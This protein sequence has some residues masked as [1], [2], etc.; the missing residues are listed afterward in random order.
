MVMERGEWKVDE[1]SWSNEAPP[2]ATPAAA[3]AG[4]R[5]GASKPAAKAQS[6][7]I[8]VAPARKLGP[9]KPPCVYKPVMTAEDME[10]CR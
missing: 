9:A 6:A 4:A 8:P 3:P 5:A 1:S 7:P 10:N 2:A